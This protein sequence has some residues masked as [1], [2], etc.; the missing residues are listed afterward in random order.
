MTF[1]NGDDYAAYN[2]HP[3]HVRFLEE[4]WFP[5]GGGV[6]GGGL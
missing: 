6:P 4:H 3:L 5:R 1:A 2:T